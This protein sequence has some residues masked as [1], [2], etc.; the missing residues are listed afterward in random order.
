[1]SA[2]LEQPPIL[3]TGPH[4]SGSTWAGSMIAAA[5]AVGYIHEPFNPTHRPGIC[6]AQTDRYF[7]DVQDDCPRKW[8]SALQKTVSFRYD[9]GAEWSSIRT[10]KDALRMV[11]DASIFAWYRLCGNRALLKDPIALFSA[12]W[13]AK[14]FDADVVV[15]VCPLAAF[16]DNLL[17]WSFPFCDLMSQF[18]L[19]E[20]H[21]V[22]YANAVWEFAEGE[23][24]IVDLG[25]LMWCILASDSALPK[26]K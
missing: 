24:G 9:A 7:L 10:P 4:R 2:A 18:R 1:M 5:P 6:A 14:T 20:F 17:E 26:G 19:L 8:A 22:P 16:V 13:I 11:R 15:L 12:E 21:L 23:Y 3:V 25:N